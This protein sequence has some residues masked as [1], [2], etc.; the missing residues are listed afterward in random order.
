PDF[1][2][3]RAGVWVDLWADVLVNYKRP[4]GSWKSFS[5]LSLY[6]QG[7]LLLI[8]EPKPTTLEGSLK[9]HVRLLSIVTINFDAGFSKQI[10]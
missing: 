5:V 10:G 7:D 9:G 8:F 4:A 6:A 2:L 1:A 3:L